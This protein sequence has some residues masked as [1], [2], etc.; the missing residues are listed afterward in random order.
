MRSGYN[1]S[2][3]VNFTSKEYGR[4]SFHGTETGLIQLQAKSIVK[5]LY[6]RETTK[7]GYERE[8]KEAICS[9]VPEGIEGMVFG[10]IYLQE[11][12]DWTERVCSEIGIEAVEPLWGREPQEIMSE[13]IDVG[14][15]AVVVA[16]QSEAIDAEWIGHRVDRDFVEYLERKGICPCGE[17]GEFH[18]LVI[19]GPIFHKRIEIIEAQTIHRDN[20]WFLDTRRYQF[21]EKESIPK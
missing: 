3:L 19:D 7:D 14:F 20:H 17:N 13:F 9:L 5:N 16:G 18:T 11:H 6:Q 12:R 15:E 1:I 4:V 10:D 8:F 21:T 2:H